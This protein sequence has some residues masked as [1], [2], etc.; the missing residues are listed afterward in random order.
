M[1]KI[2]IQKLINKSKVPQK[3][4][5]QINVKLLISDGQ[6]SK[7]FLA[8]MFNLSKFSSKKRY[9]L[10]VHM[11]GS[12]EKEQDVFKKTLEELNDD[13]IIVLLKPFV[14]FPVDSI[15]T[16]IKYTSENNIPCGVAVPF[17]QL[18]LESLRGKT[19]DDP[20]DAIKACGSFN[21]SPDGPIKVDD[22]CIMRVKQYQN[23]D[24]VA[25]P[26][27]YAKES[28]VDI[29]YG[30]SGMKDSNLPLY[31]NFEMV[32]NNTFASLLDRLMYICKK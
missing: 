18:C 13:S 9:N 25:I 28:K 11:I 7:K 12:D 21:I 16:I 22:A 5:S 26:V 32:N 8:S 23:H 30:I 2:P 14:G 1:A 3:P 29:S 17:E 24:V 4:I 10:S 31:T 27:K 19:I 6:I 20:K 15:D